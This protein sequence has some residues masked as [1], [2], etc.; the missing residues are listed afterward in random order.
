VQHNYTSSIP[1]ND[2]N[3][4]YAA[5]YHLLQAKA[6]WQHSI[7]RKIRFEL[8]AGG[9]NLLNQKYSLGNDLNAVGTRYYNPSP[10]RNY[11]F[12]VSVNM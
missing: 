3:T 9:D 2:A 11:F 6:S 7:S 8:Y 5:K 10:P 4:V 12:G 1:L